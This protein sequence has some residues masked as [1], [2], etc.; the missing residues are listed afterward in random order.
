MQAEV[1]QRLRE[2][3]RQLEHQREAE[4]LERARVVN[5]L[6]QRLEETQQQCAKLL[7]TGARHASPYTLSHSVALGVH[8]KYEVFNILLCSEECFHSSPT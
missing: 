3:I 4:Q 1:G 5:A 2:Q 6:S 7:Q 8:P